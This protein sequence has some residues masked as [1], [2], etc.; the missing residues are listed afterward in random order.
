M[1]V[2][3]IYGFFQWDYDSG[4]LILNV[5]KCENKEERTGD[6]R[7]TNAQ[8]NFHY[9]KEVPVNQLSKAEGNIKTTLR[10]LG[11]KQW[12]N[13]TE[14]FIVDD[15]VVTRQFLSE[16]MSLSINKN[17]KDIDY[18]YN[19]LDGETK[20]IRDNRK[21]CSFIPRL[22]A[23]ITTK[24]GLNEKLRY[25]KTWFLPDGHKINELENI[26]SAAISKEGWDVWQCGYKTA[27]HEQK[28]GPF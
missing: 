10:K 25:V 28:K 9:F 16:H 6:Y 13:S 5:G 8:I 18:E 21:N 4:K 3:G 11:Y 1:I 22:L 12:G 23:M 27:K 15:E 17:Y 7:G 26:K 2:S 19:T 14:Q 24:A 20:D